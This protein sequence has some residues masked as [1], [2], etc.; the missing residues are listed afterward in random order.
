MHFKLR[1]QCIFNPGSVRGWGASKLRGSLKGRKRG[2]LKGGRGPLVTDSFPFQLPPFLRRQFFVIGDV[3]LDKNGRAGV[4]CHRL[5]SGARN[6]EEATILFSKRGDLMAHRSAWVD[7]K[8]PRTTRLTESIHELSC[9][10][11]RVRIVSAVVWGCPAPPPHPPVFAFNTVDLHTIY[12]LA[13]GP[14]LLFA[15]SEAYA[16]SEKTLRQCITGTEISIQ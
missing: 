11:V 10:T 5:I 2:S 13:Q 16:Y 14:S 7:L 15:Q 9:G 6:L 3:L 8:F 1:W 4:I 12:P